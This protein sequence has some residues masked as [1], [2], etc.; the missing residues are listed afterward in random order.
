LAEFAGN[1]NT[2]GLS[3]LLD[4][5]VNV[6][7]RYKEG[8]PYFEIGKDSTALHVAAWRARHAT[9]DF[10]IERGATVNMTDVRGRTPFDLALKACV[11]S[12]WKGLRTTESME[13]LLRAGA[14]IDNI[15]LPTGYP[16]ADEL[17]RRYRNSGSSQG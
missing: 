8:D 5:G 1:G 9:V 16:E 3:R 13:S 6:A 7:E 4:L 15:Q 14:S 2:D 11:D 17:I 12:H 10:L